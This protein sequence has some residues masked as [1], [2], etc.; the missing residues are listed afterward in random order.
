MGINI[1]CV[2]YGKFVTPLVQILRYYEF[3]KIV[4]QGTDYKSVFL[5]NISSFQTNDITFFED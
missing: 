5:L 4:N 2:T 3:A 1:N